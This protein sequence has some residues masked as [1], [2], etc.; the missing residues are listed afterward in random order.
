MEVIKGDTRS[1]EPGNVKRSNLLRGVASV[2]SC[3][4]QAESKMLFTWQR[5]GN[6]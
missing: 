6:T 1:S 3:L 5:R 2:T 4:L